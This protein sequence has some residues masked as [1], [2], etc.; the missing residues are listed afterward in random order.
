M[1][2]GQQFLKIAIS[3]AEGGSFYEGNHYDGHWASGMYDY[4]VEKGIVKKYE[5]PATAEEI[6][7]TL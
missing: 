5:M 3:T 2:S 1:G 4:A 6:Y 7:H